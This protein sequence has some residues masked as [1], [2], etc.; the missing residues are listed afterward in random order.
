MHYNYNKFGFLS[1]TLCLST[2]KDIRTYFDFL[3]LGFEVHD[4]LGDYDVCKEISRLRPSL[5]L[6]VGDML[7][8][9]S[10]RLIAEIRKS[11]TYW[12][13]PLVFIKTSPCEVCKAMIWE[14]GVDAFFSLPIDSEELLARCRHLILHFER[15]ESIFKKERVEETENS[16]SFQQ[17]KDFIKKLKRATQKHLFDENFGVK[18]LVSIIG[19]SHSQ[20]HRKL[21]NSLN[22]NCGQFIKIEKLEKA[23]SLILEKN[24]TIS[25]VSHQLGFSSPSYFTRCFKEEYGLLPSELC[26]LGLQV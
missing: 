26:S 19:L 1:K 24:I 18:D 6:L 22:L 25:E 7:D 2:K 17:E 21:K 4:L 5:I 8:K 16:G 9:Q 14:S 20:L 10:L 3:P 15:L 23:K 12:K 13:I 11:K